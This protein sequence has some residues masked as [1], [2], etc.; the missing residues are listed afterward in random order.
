MAQRRPLAE[1]RIVILAEGSFGV[2]ESKTA[3]GYLRY[4]P[5]SCVA[6]LDSTKAGRDVGDVLGYAH[7]IPI[8]ATLEEAL[9][10]NPD[11]LLI[12]IAPPGGQLPD[13]WRPLIRQAIQNKMDIVS[14]LH[15]FFSR[16]AEFAPLA[17]AHGVDLWDVRQPPPDLP[18][19]T[20]RAATVKARTILTV[21]SDARVGKKITALEIAA[22]AR[23]RGI[24]AQFIATGQTGIM[25]S[26]YGICVD[27]VVA[28]F[29]AGAAECL[30]VDNADHFDWLVL[31]GQGSIIHPGYSG[32]TLGLLHGAMP[33]ALILCHQAQLQHIKRYPQPIPPLRELVRLY[34]H[35]AQPVKPTRVVGISL[36][37][38]HLSD[39]EAQEEIRQAEEA[40]GLPATDVVKFGAGKLVEAIQETVDR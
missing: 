34:E 32:V 11:V 28:D 31:E 18:V 29:I 8:V 40:T 14:G 7:G 5:H 2:L 21:G 19:A 12:G 24:N 27:A 3:A 30:V 16:D 22:E 39:A 38:F 4:H 13:S 17:Q 36:N 37:C 6:V 35:I 15:F 9:P 20:C 1:R 23:R 25:I 33:D 26:G 10:F